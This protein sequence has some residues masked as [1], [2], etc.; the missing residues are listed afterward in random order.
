MSSTPFIACSSGVATDCS[1]VSASAPVKVV[2][3]MIWGGMIVGYCATGRLRIARRPPTTVMIEMTIAT[4][5]RLTKKRDISHPFAGAPAGAPAWKGTGVTGRPSRTFWIP[6]ATT[7]SPAA[8]PSSITH[9]VPTRAPTLTGRMATL[10]SF[11]TTATWK[12]PWS[13][14]TARCGTTRAPCFTA[15]V[16]RTRPNWPGRRMLP[17][18]GKAAAIRMVP[19]IDLA[20]AEHELA[21]MRIDGPAG[22]DQ[23]ERRVAVGER[24]RRDLAA[25]AADELQI[26]ALADGDVRLDRIDARDRGEQRGRPDQIAQLSLGDAGD[27]VGERAD[28]GEPEIELGGL[29]RRPGRLDGRRGGELDL[30]VGVEL[31]AGDGARLRQRDVA[32]DVA[33]GASELRFGLRQLRPRLVEGCLERPRIDLEKDLVLLHVGALDVVLLHQVA[34]DLGPDPR[35]HVAVQRGHP[36]GA[37]GNV[38]LHHEIGRAHV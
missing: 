25:Q 23:I 34:G 35:V 10:L 5:G 21:R 33:G 31:A 4:M 2:E 20:I 18:L 12:L 27:P 38:L 16:A 28:L 37:D 17:G 22:E 7:L 15:I 26:L 29:H 24:A 11:P 36:L 3:T 14:L 19:R 6:S 32:I 13:S 30:R 9:S 8:T 1:T